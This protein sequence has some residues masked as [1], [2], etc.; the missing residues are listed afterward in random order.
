MLPSEVIEERRLTSLTC[1]Q[2][3]KK[4]Q[5]QQMQEEQARNIQDGHP[6]VWVPGQGWV[7]IDP[8][9][10]R[11][12]SSEHQEDPKAS[13]RERDEAGPS[14]KRSQGYDADSETDASE[15]QGLAS[16]KAEA[17]STQPADAELE[18]DR[19]QHR[20]E[21]R[22]EG[23]PIQSAYAL[24]QGAQIAEDSGHEGEEHDSSEG[25][26]EE[27]ETTK[28]KDTKRTDQE[29]VT[30]QDEGM[31]HGVRQGEGEP[32][33]H[34]QQDQHMSASSTAEGQQQQ[35]TAEPSHSSTE[36]VK[37]AQPRKLRTGK[38]SCMLLSL[39]ACPEPRLQL[40]SL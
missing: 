40:Q 3:C 11:Q 21:E 1:I 36:H 14:E 7:A 26:Q 9:W 38:V 6:R 4:Q 16:E 28:R 39:S 12:E 22:H 27:A 5:Q 24:S 18:D 29:N 19:K 34:C 13:A 23:K 37:E 10:D 8:D 31:G 33:Q 25:W 2:G 32:R 35:A 20:D 15:L 30:D 17:G